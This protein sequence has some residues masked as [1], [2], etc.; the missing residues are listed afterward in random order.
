[1]MTRILLIAELEKMNSQH[2]YK[3]KTNTKDAVVKTEENSRETI[4]TST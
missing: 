4:I 2:L 1:M 3:L